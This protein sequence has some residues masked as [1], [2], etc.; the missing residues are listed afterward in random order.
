MALISLFYHQCPNNTDRLCGSR[1]EALSPCLV[2]GS[3]GTFVVVHIRLPPTQRSRQDGKSACPPST[4]ML[5]VV[6]LANKLRTS[7]APSRGV[8]RKEGIYLVKRQHRRPGKRTTETC[9]LPAP[10][11]NVGG[12]KIRAPTLNGLVSIRMPK[13]C[14]YFDRLYRGTLNPFC[15]PRSLSPGFIVANS[16]T[17]SVLTEG[18]CL[19]IIWPSG[20]VHSSIGISAPDFN[21]TQGKSGYR[22]GLLMVR[23][24]SETLVLPPSCNWNRKSAAPEGLILLTIRGFLDLRPPS[25]CV[26]ITQIPDRNLCNLI[27]SWSVKPLFGARAVGTP[28]LPM[29]SRHKSKRGPGLYLNTST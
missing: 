20:T 29:N 6:K 2:S 11:F 25:V 18:A 16:S 23:K 27:R 14:M 21:S 28:G 26:V 19:R 22:S 17:F 1:L 10:Y 13:S 4:K 3:V 15:M 5:V 7:Q 9:L 12:D 8:L 24:Y